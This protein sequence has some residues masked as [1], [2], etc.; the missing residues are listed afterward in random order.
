MTFLCDKKPDIPTGLASVA[1]TRSR[2]CSKET[3]H[4]TLASFIVLFKM[5]VYIVL[6][7][8]IVYCFPYDYFEAED[9]RIYADTNFE[10]QGVRPKKLL[11]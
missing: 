10:Q 9:I 3:K 8:Q 5:L 6:T 2:S 4:S 7:N 1:R 11:N